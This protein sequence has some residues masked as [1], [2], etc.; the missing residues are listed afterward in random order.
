MPPRAFL[1]YFRTLKS[2]DRIWRAL[3]DVRVWHYRY[4]HTIERELID[5]MFSFVDE[6]AKKYQSENSEG[7]SRSLRKLTSFFQFITTSVSSQDLKSRREKINSMTQNLGISS[8]EIKPPVIRPKIPSLRPYIITILRDS[9]KPLTSQEIARIL[10]EKYSRNFPKKID[11]H[12]LQ[13]HLGMYFTRQE[14]E[15][16]PEAKKKIW[17]WYIPVTRI[18]IKNANRLS[19]A[20]SRRKLEYKNYLQWWNEKKPSTPAVKNSE[21]NKIVEE[22]SSQNL[23]M[24]RT[25]KQLIWRAETSDEI[26]Q[27]KTGKSVED[28][29]S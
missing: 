14:K 1:I 17:T 24:K 21:D 11:Q 23:P 13:Y 28:I 29:S 4:H 18:D 16:S 26:L 3:S 5:E 12:V 15:Y 20:E 10:N 19:P 9:Q 27:K 25:Q 22:K 8:D 7:A 6:V 2:R